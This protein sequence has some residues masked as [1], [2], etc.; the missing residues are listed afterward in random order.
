VVPIVNKANQQVQA[1]SQ[2]GIAGEIAGMN[3]SGYDTGLVS[4]LYYVTNG[5][6]ASLKQDFIN[7]AISPSSAPALNDLG[8]LAAGDLGQPTSVYVPPQ[9]RTIVDMD[10]KTVVIPTTIRN[11]VTT[12]NPINNLVVM[13]APDKLETGMN[14]TGYINIKIRNATTVSGMMNNYEQYLVYNPDLILYDFYVTGGSSDASLADFKAHVYPIPVV[15]IQDTVD[16]ANMTPEIK[17]AGDLL[18]NPAKAD[19]LA[20]F[21]EKVYKQVND[22]TATIPADK[23]VSVYYAEGNLG[24]QTD[25]PQS[26]HSQLITIAGG[27]NVAGSIP[28]VGSGMGNVNMEQVLAWNPDVILCGSQGAYNTIMSTSNATWRQVNAVKNGRV[29]VIPSNP[30]NW[31]DRPPGPNR[32]IGIAWTARAIYPQYYSAMN[33]TDLTRE[34]YSN[35]YNYNLSDSEVMGLLR[36]SKLQYPY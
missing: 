31:F 29:Y 17:F 21:Y 15:A 3:G 9:T 32:I 1:P 35:F 16:A 2:Q 27:N 12:H 26:F 33:M 20:A 13:L 4:Q 10:G 23:R 25:G 18:G 36:D 34:F 19:Q 5:Q 7:W 11:V 14:L 22:T 24:L 30:M 28:F 6:P 8:L